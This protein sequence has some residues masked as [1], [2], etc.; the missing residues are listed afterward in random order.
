M[1]NEYDLESDIQINQKKISLAQKDLSELYAKKAD[2]DSEIKNSRFLLKELLAARQKTL[3]DVQEIKAASI[4]KIDA[5]YSL[6]G[7]LNS[8]KDE[9]SFY[10]E[11]ISAFSAD[12]K[13]ICDIIDQYEKLTKVYISANRK[14][15]EVL[16]SERSR[17]I[18]PWTEKKSKP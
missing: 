8:I 5:V 9:E 17:K 13:K 1:H 16:D 7:Y 11:Q 12:L 6:A 14:L 15:R 3:D 2:L 10:L 18:I 4:I